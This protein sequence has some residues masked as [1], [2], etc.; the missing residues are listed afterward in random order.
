MIRQIIPYRHTLPLKHIS[1]CPLN[2][3]EQLIEKVL[4]NIH[5]TFDLRSEINKSILDN[6]YFLLQTISDVVLVPLFATSEPL[7]LCLHL[8]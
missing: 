4:V 5:V 1:T 6:P 2:L 3:T 8:Y 7:N